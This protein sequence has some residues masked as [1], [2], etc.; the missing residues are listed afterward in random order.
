MEVLL[1]KG[2]NMLMVKNILSF[3]MFV[4]KYIWMNIDVS[5]VFMMYNVIKKGWFDFEMVIVK[6]EG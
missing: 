6:G 2:M 1:D 4:K 5:D 3:F